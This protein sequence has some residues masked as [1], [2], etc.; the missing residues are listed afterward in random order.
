M[1]DPLARLVVASAVIALAGLVAL[2]FNRFR[3]QGHPS[4]TVGEVGDRPGVVL[5]T[6]GD[7]STCKR[8]IDRVE[9]E[10]IAFREVTYELESHR[11]E[12]WGVL[13]VPLT[14]ILD[15]RGAVVAVLPGVPKIKRLR[16]AVEAAGI[17][18]AT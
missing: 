9:A 12:T 16:R 4:V 15:R 11:F 1:T 14:V 18:A 10:D 7:C 6:S 17:K 3:S 2:L 8:A 5:F 13:A